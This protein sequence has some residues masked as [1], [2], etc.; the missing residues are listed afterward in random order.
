MNF[1]SGLGDAEV[2]PS[3]PPSAE[4]P[5]DSPLL[6][7]AR[8][9]DAE[10]FCTLIRDSEARLLNQALGLCRDSSLAEDLVQETLVEA[11]KS[12][13]RFDGS[14]RFS[15]WLYAILLHRHLKALRRARVRPFFCLSTEARDEALRTLHALGGTPEDAAVRQDRADGLRRCV[16]AL[17]EKHRCVVQLRFYTDAS[18]EEIAAS[19]GI[20]LGTVKSRLFHALEKL[21]AMNLSELGGESGDR[22]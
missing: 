8:A 17:P 6:A 14:C 16:Q 21:R 12:L 20:S 3:V 22:S 11:W 9:G 4:R 7:R 13:Q 5:S 19:L 15:T 2:K 1:H 18:L 10:A